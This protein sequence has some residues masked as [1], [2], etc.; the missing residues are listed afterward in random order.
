MV[1][2]TA[3]GA[4]GSADLPSRSLLAGEVAS[5]EV[6]SGAAVVVGATT[7]RWVETP[8]PTGSFS[9][10]VARSLLSVRGL[11]IPDNPAQSTARTPTATMDTTPVTNGRR[12]RSPP[13][14]ASSPRRSLDLAWPHIRPIAAR[15][16]GSSKNYQESAAMA[17][18]ATTCITCRP[19]LACCI[20]GVVSTII[21]KCQ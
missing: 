20:P 7:V 9:E 1:D 3:S 17:T 16:I 14:G 21:G 13:R 10:R 11:T 6:F 2:D 19:R 5:G 12:G 18:V 15:Q 4:F 8:E